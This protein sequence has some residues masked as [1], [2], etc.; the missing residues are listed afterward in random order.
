MKIGLWGPH[1]DGDQMKFSLGIEEQIRLASDAM[2]KIEDEAVMRGVVAIL[3]GRGW[4][5]EEP[6]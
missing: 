3:R 2:L 4:T 1:L 5:V 6:N